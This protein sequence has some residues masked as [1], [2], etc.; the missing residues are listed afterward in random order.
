MDKN[1]KPFCQQ[2]SFGKKPGKTGKAAR[3]AG[4]S[5]FSHVA[6][7]V[8]ANRG[9]KIAAQGFSWFVR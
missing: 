5:N 6:L 1:V 9:E 4:H 2:D 8:C 3:W 7:A